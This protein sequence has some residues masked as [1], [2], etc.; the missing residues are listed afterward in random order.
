[1]NPGTGTIRQDLPLGCQYKPHDTMLILK[2][3]RWRITNFIDTT[4][5]LKFLSW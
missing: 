4:F 2:L 1:M 5:T 3:R